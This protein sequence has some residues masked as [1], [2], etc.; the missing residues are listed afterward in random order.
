MPTAKAPK[1]PVRFTPA[2]TTR[3]TPT[4]VKAVLSADGKTVTLSWT[5]PGAAGE[6]GGYVPVEQLSY[7]IFDAF[8]QLTDPAIASTSE[9]VNFRPEPGT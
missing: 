2:S 4:D 9:S 7:Y 6:Q 5:A 3:S 1:P 8:G